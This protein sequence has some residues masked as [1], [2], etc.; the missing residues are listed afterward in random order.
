MMKRKI[1]VWAVLGL[2]IFASTLDVFLLQAHA[3]KASAATPFVYTDTT[4]N[5]ISGPGSDQNA[6]PI[7][8]PYTSTASGVYEATD[9]FG[10]VWV[11]TLSPQVNGGTNGTLS[12]KNPANC[13]FTP[14]AITIVS[15]STLTGAFD[16]HSHITLNGVVYTD[17]KIDADLTFDAPP[18][19]CGT[20]RINGFN[21]AHTQASITIFNLPPGG[22]VNVCP[23]SVTTTVTLDAANFD[24]FFIWQDA[25]TIT[26]SDATGV[27]FIQGTTGGDFFDD[28]SG[29]S[30]S[31]SCQSSIAATVGATTGN[32]TLRNQ[33]LSQ[34][35]PAAFQGGFATVAGCSTK[36]AFSVKIGGT[37]NSS[38]PAG[39]FKTSG[40]GG[41]PPGGGPVVP[42]CSNIKGGGGIAVRW[43]ICPVI[44]LLDSGINWLDTEIQV[45]LLVR[46][47]TGTAS[48][49][50]QNI[51]G[52]GNATTDAQLKTAW[53]RIRN[54]ALIVLI[55]IMLTMVIG[56]ALDVKYLDPYTVRRAMPRFLIAI[57]FISISWYITG[58]LINLSNILGTGLAG[59]I[60]QPFCG[61]AGGAAG[62]TGTCAS[63]LSDIVNRSATGLAGPGGLPGLVIFG[64]L[65]AGGVVSFL[66]IGSYALVALVAILI[67]FLILVMRQL[68]I[69]VLIMLAPVA[70]LS[71]VFPG[72]NKLWKTWWETFS[73]LLLLFPVIMILVSAG[74]I[75]A[76]LIGTLV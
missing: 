75:F 60:T 26:T 5:T 41:G 64:G 53:G 58:F 39:T 38:K 42:T 61:N 14:V 51:G 74:K 68:V 30:G 16:D 71:W 67:G 25:G 69:V 37:A 66:V 35:W 54:V 2:V 65:I 1:S 48:T 23:P 28:G 50:A 3:P 45:L 47:P 56:T 19:T 22:G 76:I 57:V 7:I 59:L 18:N 4:G 36:A 11:I 6:P 52:L 13:A 73:R 17:P 62:A 49:P 32:I 12:S 27:V 20:N 46:D 33:N 10:C 8:P 9:G 21:G 24:V 70:I 31:A 34:G 63:T 40:G 44:E 15:A 43:F 72:N 29:R 55:P